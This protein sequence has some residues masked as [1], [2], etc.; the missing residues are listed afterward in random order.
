MLRHA[1]AACLLGVVL[2]A[3]GAGTPASGKATGT[4]TGHVQIRAC[5]GAYRP[6]QTGC[7]TQLAAGI[8]LTFR[9]ATA[10]A[11]ASE[12]T[13]TTDPNGAYRADLAP[14]TYLVIAA[15]RGGLQGPRQVVVVAGRTVTADFVYTI[16]LL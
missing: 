11:N 5:G 4:V 10:P 7:P 1:I 16:Q 9:L 6:E 13:V 12:K 3:C 14:G 15:G 8:G 2:S